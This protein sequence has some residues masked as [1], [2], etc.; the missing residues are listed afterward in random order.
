[1]QSYLKY[2]EHY[3]RKAEA[4]PLQE[5][6]YGFVLQPKADSQGSKIPFRDYRWIGPF[7]VQKVLTNK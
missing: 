1:M 5:K 7:I 3:D 4:V 6:E 2:K